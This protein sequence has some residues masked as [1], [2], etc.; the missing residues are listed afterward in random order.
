VHPSVIGNLRA[1]PEEQPGGHFSGDDTGSIARETDPED[2]WLDPLCLALV[3]LEAGQPG[4]NDLATC[5]QVL[6]AGGFDADRVPWVPPSWRPVL[7]GLLANRPSHPSAPVRQPDRT[8]IVDSSQNS[9]RPE[10]V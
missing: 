1:Q 5:Y 4:A 9:P 7:Q 2:A 10:A 8:T 6:T 3:R